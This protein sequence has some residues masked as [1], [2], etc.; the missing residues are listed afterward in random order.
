MAKANARKKEND[1]SYERRLLKERL[2]E[3]HLYAD[4]DEKK[5]LMQRM[6]S[7]GYWCLGRDRKSVV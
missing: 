4:E 3:D 5:K 6:L 2:K 7:C 1:A